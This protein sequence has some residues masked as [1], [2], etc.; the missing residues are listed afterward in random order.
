MR[1][2][3][4]EIN[5]RQAQQDAQHYMTFSPEQ[6]ERDI[7][8]PAA[9]G[10]PGINGMAIEMLPSPQYDAFKARYRAARDHTGEFAG[11]PSLNYPTQND[12]RIQE[13]LAPWQ[14]PGAPTYAEMFPS[15]PPLF[16]PR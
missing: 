14:L 9:N 16:E 5:A 1:D 2:E 10:D 8:Q 3:S 13:S 12:I 7:I 15:A 4:D 11:H 6:L